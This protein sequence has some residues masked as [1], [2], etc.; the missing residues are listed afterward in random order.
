MAYDL[1]IWLHQK[2]TTTNINGRYIGVFDANTGGTAIAGPTQ[3]ADT[4]EVTLGLTG[5]NQTRYI[6]FGSTTACEDTN[7]TFKA[8]TTHDGDVPNIFS[9]GNRWQINPGATSSIILLEFEES[10]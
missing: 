1:T 7:Y 9:N 10:S 6:G 8:V 5:T 4:G 3:T 2:G